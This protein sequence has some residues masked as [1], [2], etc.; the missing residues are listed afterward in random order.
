[1][2][3]T[4]TPLRVSFFGGGTDLPAFYEQYEGAVL[5]AAINRYV[6]I[7]LHPYHER[8]YAL[9]YSQT[10]V[11]DKVD[12]IQHRLIRECFRM[13][14][15]QPGIELS[16]FAD[17]TSSGSG[18]G[19]SSAFA[20]GLLKALHAF[21]GHHL[22]PASCADLACQVEIERLGDP[23]GKQD[24]YASAFGGLNYYR[25]LPDGRVLVDPVILDRESR[26]TL[27]RR[28]VLVDTG[29]TR[30]AGAILSEQS[31]R[32][33]G[34]GATV[35][36]LLAMREQAVTA[37]HLLHQRDLDGFGRL[38]NEAWALKRQVSAGISDPEIEALYQAG[39][40]AGA[41][42]GKLLGAGGGGFVLFY[43]PESALPSLT[44]AVAPRKVQTFRVD[45]QGT[46]VAFLGQD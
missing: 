13:V 9:K 19:S 32:T 41:L 37:R 20:V 2:L 38:L 28:L 30:S 18:L 31:R 17:I 12:E 46:R 27:E 24:Q 8:Q 23:I 14:D 15:A 6:Y 39:L 1:M 16:S 40:D 11:V 4:Q 35:E 25:F 22:A 34:G 7:A 42:G 29:R 45:A 3:I 5:S 43:C 21:Q 44:A 26:E 33:K 10:E 36:L